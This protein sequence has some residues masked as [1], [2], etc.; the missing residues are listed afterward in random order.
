V[1]SLSDILQ[2]F[3]DEI[4][5]SIFGVSKNHPYRT[6][7]ISDSSKID[8]YQRSQPRQPLAKIPQKPDLTH[9]GGFEISRTSKVDNRPG[10]RT[11]PNNPE[12]Q[13]IIDKLTRTIDSSK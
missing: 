12:T 13:A 8:R 6:D 1:S 10:S 2:Q 4:R 11:K 3:F 9:Q 7:V 5:R